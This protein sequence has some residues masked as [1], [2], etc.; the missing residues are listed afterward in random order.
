[1][2][3]LLAIDIGNTNT[4]LGI[5]KDGV[6]LHSWRITTGNLQTVDELGI[7]VLELLR[8]RG[9]QTA[10]IRHVGI[11]SVVPDVTTI[12][13]SVATTYIGRESFTVGHHLDL[14]I[15]IIYDDPRAVG[16]DRLANVIAAM[17]RF[18]GPGVVIDLG[19]ATTFDV[20]ND[21]GDYL[22]GVIA[23]GIETSALSLHR[24]A[25]KLPRINLELPDTIIAKNTTAAMQN[26]ILLG[27]LKSAEGIIGEIQKEFD[28]PLKLTITGGFSTF[29]RT[30]SVLHMQQVPDLVL[31][32]VYQIGHRLGYC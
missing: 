18:G 30:H 31:E 28:Q 1:M 14:G 20:Y 12:Y 4:V 5:M 23:P 17:H 15:K 2:N 3:Y 6:V 19:T 10:D 32:G 11:C 16:A 13:Q 9:Y 21:K 26:G 22:G 24:R 8:N 7:L 27:S 25:A 29:I